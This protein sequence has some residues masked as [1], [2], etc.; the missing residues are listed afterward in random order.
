MKYIKLFEEIKYTPDQ[1][2]L[3]AKLRYKLNKFFGKNCCGVSKVRFIQD[4]TYSYGSVEYSAYTGSTILFR[5]SLPSF[6][7]SDNIIDYEKKIDLFTKLAKYMELEKS[8]NFSDTEYQLTEEQMKD[9]IFRMEYIDT[10][11]DAKK[12]NL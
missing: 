9:L 1:K 10:M 6:I 4:K 12:Y 11:E 5:I 3:V 8:Y 2:K 7:Y